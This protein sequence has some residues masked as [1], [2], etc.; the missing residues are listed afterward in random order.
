MAVHGKGKETDVAAT[1][2]GIRKI[3]VSFWYV[4]ECKKPS[5]RNVSLVRIMA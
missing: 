3:W 4:D 1:M 2:F 5:T